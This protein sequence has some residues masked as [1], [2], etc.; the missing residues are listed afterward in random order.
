MPE[1]ARWELL[2]GE[3]IQ[4]PPAEEP[5]AALHLAL[6]YVLRAH[7]AEGFAVAF[8]MLTRTS[9]DTD[10][11]P[12]VSIYPTAR[13]PHTRGRQ[14][15]ALAFEIV[16]RQSMDIPTRKAIALLRRGVRRV[17]AIDIRA[18]PRTFL[19]FDMDASAWIALP[20]DGILQD[21]TL[22]LPIPVNDL[23]HTESADGAVVR[24]LIARKVPEMM[25]GLEARR[26]R[27]DKERAS[28]EAESQRA[29]TAEARAE[30]ER[31]RREAAEARAEAERE[32]REAAE[33]RSEHDEQERE[34]VEAE[35]DAMA[36]ELASLKA[37]LGQK[38]T[39]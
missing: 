16:S 5:H 1:G 24:A 13:N 3:R 21:S 39:D 35:R 37:R 11:A 12:S 22:V 4:I 8:Y 17:F 14:L 38:P 19:E 26:R 32:R 20:L 30:T 10:I 18:R 25:A 36:A 34:R 33:A 28:A 2:D 6:G 31:Q 15:E 9:E 27:A 29:D 23:L 7:V